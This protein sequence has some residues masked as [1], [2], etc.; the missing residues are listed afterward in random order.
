MNNRR[1]IIP[2]ATALTL[3]ILLFPSAYA[4]SGGSPLIVD[5]G[6]LDRSSPDTPTKPEGRH[7]SKTGTNSRVQQSKEFRIEKIVVD[8]AISVPDTAKLTQPFIGRLSSVEVLTA[9]ASTLAAVYPKHDVAFYTVEITALDADTGSVR[10]TAQEGYVTEVSVKG[11]VGPSWHRRV[12][13]IMAPL[14]AEKPLSR[15]SYEKL[16]VL[17]ANINGL[18]VDASMRSSNANGGIAIDVEV[19][20]RMPSATIGFHNYGSELIGADT[21]EGFAQ[22]P[23]IFSPGDEATI[24]YSAPTNFHNSHYLSGSYMMPL[25]AAGTALR[26]TGGVLRTRTFFDLLHGRAIQSGATISRPLLQRF[27][28]SV[29]GAI[30]FDFINLDNA[31]LGYRLTDDRTRTL[32][33]SLNY[34]E[35]SA[36]HRVEAEV[37]GS[38]GVAG[39]GARSTTSEE[40][41]NFSKV[42]LR[43]NYT[44]QVAKNAILRLKG[45]AQVSASPLPV[46]EQLAIGGSDFGRGLSA[47]LIAG[48]RGFAASGEL[49]LVPAMPKPLSGSE[50]YAFVDGASIRYMNRD[51]FAGYSYRNVSI[52]AGARLRFDDKVGIDL[53]GASVVRGPYEGFADNWRMFVTARFKIGR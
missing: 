5:R 30:G 45:M 21:V 1:N 9:L 3:A 46:A 16:L 49:A 12:K 48:D 35:E 36:R 8:G 15:S 31:L 50:F 22:W 13:A 20:R 32:R 2:S 53:G 7:I 6:R 18:T 51:V 47:G 4:Q 19:R 17:L 41:P 40:R 37:I 52:G 43:V 14:L 42:N 25:D 23:G 39:L 28:R 38:K 27:G 44:R 24:Y 29:T 11:D 10:L 33:A 34:V 26:V